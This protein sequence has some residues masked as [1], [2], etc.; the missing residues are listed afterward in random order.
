MCATSVEGQAFRRWGGGEVGEREGRWG[1]SVKVEDLKLL[2]KQEKENM[3]MK[4]KTKD[5][6]IQT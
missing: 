3:M 6:R 1:G 4:K 5:L 2:T